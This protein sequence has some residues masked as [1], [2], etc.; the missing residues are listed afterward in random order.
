MRCP[1]SDL[2]REGCIVSK[3]CG[4]RKYV[5]KVDVNTTTYQIGIGDIIT[6]PSNADRLTINFRNNNGVDCIISPEGT[7]GIVGDFDR[8]PAGQSR[9]YNFDDWGP[10][11]NREWTLVGQAGACVVVVTEVYFLV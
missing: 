10:I 11:V 5:D 1:S 6:I 9:L 2:L 7:Q 4:P 3:V 8:I